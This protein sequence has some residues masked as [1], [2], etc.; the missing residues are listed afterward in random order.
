[1]LRGTID[2]VDLLRDAAAASDGVMHLA[3]MHDL[4]FAGGFA[5]AADADRLVVETLG[6]VLAGSDRSLVIASGTLG[7]APGRMATERD[8]HDIDPALTAL[9]A[10]PAT[11]HGTA[12]VVL[13]LAPAHF[14]WMA[15]F[16]GLDSPASSALTRALLAWEPTRL[17]LIDDLDE[18]H[19]FE[20]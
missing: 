2:D 17:G 20:R 19:Y 10:G 5:H 11:R 16:I 18:G 14:T 12:E 8:G 13:S 15:G 7:V 6:D 1:V 3:F 9:G 4:A